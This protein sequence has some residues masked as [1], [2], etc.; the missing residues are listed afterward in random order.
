MTVL[1]ALPALE[2][3]VSY[4]EQVV[5]A[6]TFENCDLHDNPFRHAAA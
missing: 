6:V 1:L 2:M 3:C 4:R 5:R